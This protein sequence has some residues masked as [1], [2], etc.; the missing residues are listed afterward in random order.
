MGEIASQTLSS[1]SPYVNLF[2]LIKIHFYNVSYILSNVVG[3]LQIVSQSTVLTSL[4]VD[5]YVTPILQ[6]KGPRI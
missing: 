1:L 4:E 6:L 2:L 3:S 5:I